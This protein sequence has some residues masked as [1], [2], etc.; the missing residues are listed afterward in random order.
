MSDMYKTYFYDMNRWMMLKL[1]GIQISDYLLE[2][3]YKN[4]IIYGLNDMG[5]RLLEELSKTQVNVC[6]VIDK[7]ASNLH[8]QYDVRDFED[9][10]EPADAVI[11]MLPMYFEE[12]KKD[13]ERRCICP[14][15]S[16]E[17]ILYGIPL[18]GVDYE[19]GR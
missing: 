19:E 6:C 1:R 12:I 17:A 18:S 8:T 10:W 15:L 13:V 14:V 16:F 11:V 2:N 3:G 9:E 7:N 4:V 5:K